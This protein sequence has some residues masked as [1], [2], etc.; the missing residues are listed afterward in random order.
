MQLADDKLRRHVIR[1]DSGIWSEVELKYELNAEKSECR[2][3][4]KALKKVRHYLYAIKFT[5]ETN[6][7][8]LIA[9]LNRTA[10]DVPEALINRWL[11]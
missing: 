4:I 6:T 5:I 10:S 2:G 1:Y 11:A 8:I 9:Q 7:R 3:L